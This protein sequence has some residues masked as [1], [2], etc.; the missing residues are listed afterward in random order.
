MSADLEL[1]VHTYRRRQSWEPLD[2]SRVAAN[3]PGW[4]PLLMQERANRIW[5]AINGL[6]P[7]EKRALI[8]VVLEGESL[9][10]A[11]T[12]QGVSAMTMQR[13]LKRALSQL[14]Q[15]LGDQDSSL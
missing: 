3:E 13:R 14:R 4:Q 15:Q 8:E 12:K 7:S 11:G 6:A 1:N 5:K 2:E 10:A 9:R